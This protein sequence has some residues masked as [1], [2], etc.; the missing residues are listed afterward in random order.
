MSNLLTITIRIPV[1]VL[2]L[3]LVSFIQAQAQNPIPNSG[4]EAWSGGLPDGWVAAGTI[5]GTGPITQ[6]DDSHTGSFA[7]RGEPIA[8]GDGVLPPFLAAGDLANPGFAVSQR[9]A[10]LTA[11]LKYFPLNRDSLSIEVFMNIGF[12]TIGSG[13]MSFQ[14]TISSYSQFSIPITYMTSGVPDRAIINVV[15]RSVGNDLPA[16]GT[17]FL[18]DDWEFDAMTTSVET[19]PIRVPEKFSLAQNFPNPFNPETLISF[20]LRQQTSTRLEVYNVLG[21]RIRVLVDSPLAA[22]NHQ[23]RWN[24][25]DDF[26]Q[27]VSSGVYVYRLTTANRSESRKMLLLQ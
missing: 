17:F 26:G 3:L 1:R 8:F 21:Q 5:P 24:G 6:S 14:D 20:D 12:N 15:V 10:S 11:F 9:H 22:G 25:T 16:V 2:V 23:V 18:L 27:V 13:Q 4:F 19:D 7:A